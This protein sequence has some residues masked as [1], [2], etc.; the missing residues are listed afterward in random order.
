MAASG[1]TTASDSAFI[2]VLHTTSHSLRTDRIEKI[3]ERQSILDA[4][5]FPL[6]GGGSQI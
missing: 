5:L 6:I 1:P 4:G 2:P 3:F